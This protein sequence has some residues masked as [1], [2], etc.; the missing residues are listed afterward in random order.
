MD[1]E[2]DHDIAANT[3][4][5]LLELMK[6]AKPARVAAAAASFKDGEPCGTDVK[7]IKV[8]KKSMA[9]AMHTGGFMMLRD[10]NIKMISP[11]TKVAVVY[12]ASP[13]S[14]C[15]SEKSIPKAGN[16]RALAVFGFASFDGNVHLTAENFADFQHL[17]LSDLNYDDFVLTL[18][19]DKRR[20][21]ERPAKKVIGWK[22]KEFG[23]ASNG[24]VFVPSS[25]GCQERAKGVQRYMCL[26]VFFCTACWILC[27]VN[28]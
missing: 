9:R 5:N 12:S 25:S 13:A 28:F 18:T 4:S 24:V 19:K 1:H 7:A 14:P 10:F 23:L 8:D 6:T 20:E 11:G 17:H 3:G 22:F 21:R 16:G 2:S 26:D 15:D 27:A